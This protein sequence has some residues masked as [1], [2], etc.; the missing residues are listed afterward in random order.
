[1]K[2]I[3]KEY[4][5]IRYMNHARGLIKQGAWLSTMDERDMWADMS[6]SKLSMN[7][8]Y[9]GIVVVQCYSTNIAKS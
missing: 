8:N 6:W 5:E 3:V 7:L 1:M 9:N 4:T 2:A